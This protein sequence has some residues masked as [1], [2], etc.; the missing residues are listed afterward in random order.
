LNA[1]GETASVTFDG[2]VV[3]G[4]ISAPLL[5]QVRQFITLNRAALLEY[6]EQQ[7]STDELQDR[8]IRV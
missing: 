2:T 5:E 4:D 1:R 8:L 3:A 7:I 6:W